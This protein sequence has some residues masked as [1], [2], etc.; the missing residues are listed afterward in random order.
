[1][2]R[3]LFQSLVRKHVKSARL[4]SNLT[5]THTHAARVATPMPAGECSSPFNKNRSFAI[6]IVLWVTAIASIVVVGVQ[7]A[8]F[9]EAVGGREALA[10]V[11][12]QWAARAGIET[13]IARLEFATLNPDTSGTLTLIDD[14]AANAEGTLDNAL[15]NISHDSPTGRVLGPDDAHAKININLMPR[16]SLL[17]LPGMTEDVADAILDW[18][19]SDD[20]TRELGAEIG[21]YRAQRYSVEP[22][23][24]PIRSIAELE[25]VAGVDPVLVRAEDWNLNGLLDPNEDDGD[26]SWPPDNADG[27]LDAGWSGIITAAST[28]DV[29]AASGE[30]RLDLKSAS[31]SSVVQRTGVENDQARAI[32]GYA[33]ALT[34]TPQFMRDYI[35]FDLRSLDE[36]ANGGEIRGGRVVPAQGQARSNV[37]AL[38]PEQLAKL[39]DECSMGPAPTTAGPG[40]LN[41]NTC[42]AETLQYIPQI[43]PALADTIIFERESR[44]EGFTSVADLASVPGV[45]RARAAALFDITGVRSNAFVVTSRGRDARS[46]IEFEITATLDRSRVPLVIQEI[47]VR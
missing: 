45:G 6:L 1:M 36:V 43:D 30:E 12:A 10:R 8:A 46:G 3:F 44:P 13:I 41:L 17:T 33:Q 19:D 31:E 34:P 5:R 24:A 35:R 16:D 26:E 14:L 21:F 37:R 25:L 18:I 23:N 7:Q 11:R 4:T 9:S 40:K 29:L 42:A 38:T 15:F 22:R 47:V 2:T 28:S 20:D 32:V 27:R 39:L